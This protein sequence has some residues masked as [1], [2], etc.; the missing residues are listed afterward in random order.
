M[1]RYQSLDTL[2]QL[3][4]DSIA[5]KVV[6]DA[7][8]DPF[9]FFRQHAVDAFDHYLGP[10]SV[11][12][13]AKVN[14]LVLHDPDSR[15]RADALSTLYSLGGDRYSATYRQALSDTSYAVMGSALIVEM[16]TRPKEIPGLIKRFENYNTMYTVLPLAGYFID[17]ADYSRYNWFVEKM[18]NMKWDGLWY[19]V[20]YF[21]EYLMKAPENE[22]RRGIA[23][24][25]KY[26]RY[27]N[28]QYVRLASYQALGLL[29]DVSGVNQ[30]LK[31]IR[32]NEKNDTLQRLYQYYG[33]SQGEE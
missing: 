25:E 6:F 15:V 24:L 10:D 23:V 13:M 33:P 14:E 3:M 17:Q 8:S 1:P 26:A 19:M 27:H 12:L 9:W 7:L 21:G 2:S 5:E 16:Q 11:E 32:K 30:I 29:T 28:S 20:R 22:Q 31:D 18:A 4:T